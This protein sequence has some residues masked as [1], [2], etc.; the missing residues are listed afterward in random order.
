M[1]EVNVLN[2]DAT[3]GS[4][5][6]STYGL[7]MVTKYTYENGHH[8]RRERDFFG[9]E[10]IRTEEI[11]GSSVY[12]SNIQ[13]FYNNS[14]FLNGTLRDSKTYDASGNLLSAS[15]NTYKL[16][17][18]KDSNTKINLATVLPDS[19]DTGGKEGRKMAVVLLD[20]TENRTYESG[21]N[22]LTA[23]SFTY[24]DRGQIINYKY[25]SPSTSYNSAI[26]YYTLNNNIL[27]VPKSITVNPEL[28]PVITDTEKRKLILIPVISPK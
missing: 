20:K 13:T 12:R 16:Y 21:G 6:V 11:T 19:F 18:F 24:N 28:V 10:K 8:D 14:Y 1:K 7:D 27:N 23:T 2:P 25:V 17:K 5:L 15:V 22:L 26:N 9:F 4:H 3:S